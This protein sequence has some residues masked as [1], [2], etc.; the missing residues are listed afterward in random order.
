M[1]DG[2]ESLA[3]EEYQR[4]EVFFETALKEKPEDKKARNYLSGTKN[5]DELLEF[6][7]KGDLEEGVNTASKIL[8]NKDT[9]SSIKK[10][11]EALNLE[12]TAVQTEM[13]THT[14]TYTEAEA[15]SKEKKY[16]DSNKKLETILDVDLNGPFFDTLL[17]QANNLKKANDGEINRESEQR[18]LEEAKIEEEQQ[19]A[20]E[21]E[22]ERVAEEQQTAS[23]SGIIPEK[24]RGH[25]GEAGANT[26]LFELTATHYIDSIG[27]KEYRII[28][29][30]T[31]DGVLVLSW[32]LED[33][34]DKYG[35]A[36]LGPGPQ[37]FMYVINADD[38]LSS[39]S[40]ADLQR[41][42]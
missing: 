18:K 42:S 29:V 4:A 13:A 34:S 14:Q 32:D 11:A 21:A 23:Q 17:S 38:T 3:G 8:N 10:K 9:P 12:L 36:S 27:G 5:L 24:F 1:T 28:N 16:E 33:F 40:G 6:K 2:I 26:S 22:A 15:L 31:Q 20:A 7:E 25:W 35:A 39:M 37:P 19:A 30:S 41:I